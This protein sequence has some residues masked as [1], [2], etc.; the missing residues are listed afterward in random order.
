MFC[1]LGT[2]MICDVRCTFAVGI[3]LCML[4]LRTFVCVSVKVSSDPYSA[5]PYLLAECKGMVFCEVYLH[6]GFG[7]TL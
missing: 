6:T 7:W 2:D 5:L 4:P 3:I 1:T